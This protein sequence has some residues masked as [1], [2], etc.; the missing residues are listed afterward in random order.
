MPDQH[1]PEVIGETHLR[2][3]DGTTWPRPDL[4]SDQGHGIGWK[5][6]YTDEPLTRADRMRLASIV[7]AYGY[8]LLETNR[9]RRDQV[10]RDV[11]TALRTTTGQT[12]TSQIPPG[13]D[14]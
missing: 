6:R 12:T 14:D 2:L 1:T 5:L 8:L 7:H 11:K 9:A 10:C 3:S 13:Q 4:E